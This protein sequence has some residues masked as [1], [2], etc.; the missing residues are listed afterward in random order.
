MSIKKIL[1]AFL[2]TAVILSSFSFLGDVIGLS[3]TASALSESEEIMAADANSSLA[4]QT[5]PAVEIGNTP[6]LITNGDFENGSTG[7]DLTNSGGSAQVTKLTSGGNT[8][9]VLGTR[10]RWVI[11]SGIAL[12]KNTYYVL[13]LDV[14]S[15]APNADRTKTYFY[16]E[17]DNNPDGTGKVADLADKWDYLNDAINNTWVTKEVV[18]NSGDNNI[19]YFAFY[20]GDSTYWSYFDNFN[21]QKIGSAD[22][23]LLNGETK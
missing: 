8:T 21:L 22:S 10:K 4:F 20:E 14:C 13:T 6:N 1:S 9:N 12:E 11:S 15:T 17:S 18:F 23:V 5:M 3:I 2:A 7:W 19:V 16:I